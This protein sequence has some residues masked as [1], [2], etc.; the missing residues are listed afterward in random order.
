ME[1][2]SEKGSGGWTMWV[3]ECCAEQHREFP[4]GPVVRTLSF[5]CREFRVRSLV[6]EFRSHKPY[7]TAKKKKKKYRLNSDLIPSISLS[8]C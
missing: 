5:H 2:K 6:R 1:D 7:G 4:G 3:S 8:G